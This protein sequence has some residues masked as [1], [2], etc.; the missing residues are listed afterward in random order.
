[1]DHVS[2]HNA[3]QQMV[4]PHEWI[5]SHVAAGQSKSAVRPNFPTPGPISIVNWLYVQR[6][7]GLTLWFHVANICCCAT[8]QTAPLQLT[9]SANDHCDV[10]IISSQVWRRETLSQLCSLRGPTNVLLDPEDGGEQY[11][12]NICQYWPID[13][14]LFHTIC[15]F[16]QTAVIISDVAGG[17]ISI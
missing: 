5:L 11:L 7:D 1:M 8:L 3:H 16:M 12:R 6:T 13:T 2:I 17:N 14:K 9:H 10:L 15:S 4:W